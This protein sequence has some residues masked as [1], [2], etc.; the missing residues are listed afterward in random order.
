MVGVYN[1]RNPCPEP[2]TCVPSLNSR[3]QCL[4]L[5]HLTVALLCVRS[6]EAALTRRMAD[7]EHGRILS[8]LFWGQGGDF[9]T[10]RVLEEDAVG[11]VGM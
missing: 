7:I 1:D 8:A 5:L 10:L 9:E 4:L 11:G 6:W 2:P 3:A